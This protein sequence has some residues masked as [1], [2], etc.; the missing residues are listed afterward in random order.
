MKRYTRS[1]NVPGKVVIV[2]GGIAGCAA[3]IS[4]R[5][6]GARVVVLERTDMLLGGAN[7]AGR[8]NYNGKM[9]LAEECKAMGVGEVHQALESI[10]LHRGN[11]VDEEHA[12]IYNTAVAEPTIRRLL[13]DRGVEL[14][15]YKLVNKVFVEKGR[16]RAVAARSS[17]PVQGDAFIDATAGYGGVNNCRKYGAGCVMC[18]YYRCPTFGN[19]VSIA[20]L[21][22]APELARYRADGTPGLMS[23]STRLYKDSLD[24]DLQAELKAKGAVS[25][26][27]PAE[28]VD[29]SHQGKIGE[30]R[31]SR[32][33]ERLNMVDI[34]SC[35]MCVALHPM[36]LDQLRKLPGLRNATVEDPLGG[37][38]GGNS[39]G[40]LSMAPRD[41]TLRVQ[42][43]HNLFV[44]GE[45]AGPGTGVDETISSGVLAGFNAARVAVGE[46][47]LVLPTGTAIGDL[48][49]F[50]GE[51]MQT[52]EGLGQGCSAGH[53]LY[54]ERMK[55][56][57][58]YTTDVAA[59]R[60]RVE[61]AGVKDIFA[62]TP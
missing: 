25:V 44:A 3:A 20:T 16:F 4:A 8:M 37:T 13:R 42:G 11:I 40:K 43:F 51:L 50:S 19:R 48:V 38:I 12:Y 46:E 27:L 10:T 39:V 24:P 47:P 56:L 35:V 14:Q 41:D 29:H 15:F 49:H 45:K 9:I 21:A 58:F 34:G 62:R 28:M 23:G 2:G 54:F 53:G 5:K 57:G 55:Q 31:T 60:A 6:A 7:R 18:V 1:D 59:I 33:L 32:Q 17:S 61:K 26:K 30:I 52:R 36:P 22:G